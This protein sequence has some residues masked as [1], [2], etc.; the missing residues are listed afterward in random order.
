MFQCFLTEHYQ[1]MIWAISIGCFLMDWWNLSICKYLRYQIIDFFIYHSKDTW[2]QT[3][4]VSN[5]YMLQILV[6]KQA[7]RLNLL[8]YLQR[9]AGKQH[10]SPPPRCL[11]VINQ[12]KIAVRTFNTPLW[13]NL[14]PSNETWNIIQIRQFLHERCHQSRIQDKMYSYQNKVSSTYSLIHEA[15]KLSLEQL[16]EFSAFFQFSITSNRILTSGTLP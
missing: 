4:C 1:E 7:P 9:S 5:L 11:P 15:N 14:V 13:S 2:V 6:A 8:F 10:R 16:L 3:M 12:F